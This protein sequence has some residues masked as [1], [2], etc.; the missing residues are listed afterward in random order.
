MF[1]EHDKTSRKLKT[2]FTVKR[3][4]SS[5]GFTFVEMLTLILMLSLLVS[6]SVPVLVR[7]KQKSVQ[8]YCQSNLR[9]IGV[10]L[11]MYANANQDYLPG[12]TVG[13]VQPVYDNKSKHELAWFLARPLNL[14]EPS[15]IPARAELLICPA[16]QSE[17]G[18]TVQ[19]QSYLLNESVTVSKTV[20][21]PPFGHAQEPLAAPLKLS[22]VAASAPT[23][24]VWAMTDADK[25]NVNPTLS[26]WHQLPYRPVHGEIRNR[27]YFDG[28]AAAQNW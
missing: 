22:T 21:Q 8:E 10:A 18:S 23:S 9:Q 12:P 20:R 17:E 4:V 27:L 2:L 11:Q 5:G 24:R 6:L 13:L 28:H 1:S 14:P 3:D 7:A 15:P 26:A 16:S 25:G 19:V